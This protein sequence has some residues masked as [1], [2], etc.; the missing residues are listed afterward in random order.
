[1]GLM[2]HNRGMRVEINQGEIPV[3]KKMTIV[4]TR[5]ISTFMKEAATSS[6]KQMPR[7]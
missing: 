7:R 1:M 5:K 3:A 4:L 2:G 6:Q